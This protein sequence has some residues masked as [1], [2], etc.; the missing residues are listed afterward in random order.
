MV[1]DD[2]V[3]ALELH[4]KVNQQ[5]NTKN[6]SE[7]RNTSHCDNGNGVSNLTRNKENINSNSSTHKISLDQDHCSNLHTRDNADDVRRE[8]SSYILNSA[9]NLGNTQRRRGDSKSSRTLQHR[10]HSALFAFERKVPSEKIEATR[11]PSKSCLRC[12]CI[13][14]KV[15][16]GKMLREDTKVTGERRQ[17]RDDTD[18][19][20]LRCETIC[21]NSNRRTT[22]LS[23]KAKS[24]FRK[25]SRLAT[26]NDSDCTLMLPGPRR[27]KDKQYRYERTRL[28]VSQLSRRR[29][30]IN[31][32]NSIRMKSNA[33]KRSRIDR[34]RFLANLHRADVHRFEQPSSIP[35]ETQQLLNKSYWEYYRKLKRRNALT[36]PDIAREEDKCSNEMQSRANLPASRTLQQCSVLSCMI[37]KTL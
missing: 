36:G 25:R 2:V 8:N 18:K 15:S 6:M 4:I 31:G 28:K 35:L 23:R 37:N 27:I 16:S 3:G 30:W 14:A 19:T 13:K 22:N 21:F 11:I 10:S 1:R 12:S 9:E 32:I 33:S 24:F 7:N 26:T 20:K 17:K 34:S 29:N 5:H